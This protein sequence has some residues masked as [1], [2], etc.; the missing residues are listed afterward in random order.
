MSRDISTKYIP[1]FGC[2]VGQFSTADIRI[3]NNDQSE[4]DV[5]KLRDDYDKMVQDIEKKKVEFIGNFR[6][7]AFM[8][9]MAENKN[10]SDKILNWVPIWLRDIFMDINFAKV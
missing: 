8:A 7:N 1:P 3:L 10:I 4:K 9:E 5:V 2:G 6:M